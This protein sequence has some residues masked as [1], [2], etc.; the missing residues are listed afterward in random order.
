MIQMR[1]QTWSVLVWTILRVWGQCNRGRGVMWEPDIVLPVAAAP[2]EAAIP[3]RAGGE[4]PRRRQMQQGHP[5][6]HALVQRTG[7]HAL[8]AHQW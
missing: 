1:K 3:G 2:Q 8:H 7:T 6:A 5:P 4:A